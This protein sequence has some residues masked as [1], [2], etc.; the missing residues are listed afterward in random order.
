MER[1]IISGGAPLL[2][3]VRISGAKNAALPI[4]AAAIMTDETLTLQNVPDLSDITQMLLLLEHHGAHI[5]QDKQQK[6]CS[7]QVANIT[8]HVAKY[9]IVRKMRASILVLGPLL[10]R[11][12]EAKVSFPGGCAIGTRPVNV[13]IDGLRMLGAEI[14]V[15]SGYINAVA[16]KNGLKGADIALPIVSVTGTENLLMAATLAEGRT[17]LRNAAK[18][19]EVCDLARCL[20]KMGA[21]IEGIGTDTLVVDGV[22]AL[23]GA[24][25]TII[26]DRIEA[27]TYAAGAVITHG[28]VLLE[29]VVYGDLA[30]FW[31]SLERAGARI[32]VESRIAGGAKEADR[33]PDRLLSNVVESQIAKEADRQPDRLHSSVVEAQIAKE[34]GQQPDRLHS[35]VLVEMTQDIRGVDV[36]TGPYP[37]FPT[38]LQAQFMALMTI[39]SGAAMITETI[40]ENRFMH[41]LELC[42]MGADITVHGGSALV[43]GVKW[44]TGTQVM[45][46][47]IRASV[48]L[49]LAGAATSGTTEIHRIYHIDRGYECIEK[50][51]RGC[52]VNIERAPAE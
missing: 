30:V 33:Q 42:R 35:S 26:P 7:L 45:A 41:V 19:P 27:G 16:S 14:T 38:D 2:G 24:N 37:G 13:H 3:T 4:M 23:H 40:F 43:R 48:S 52:G 8:D 31:E 44:L 11:H 5:T 10:A 34:T 17:I 15:S 18:E 32:S 21:K 9:D 49:V 46:T 51:L 22:S 39:C 25:H 1:I 20:I 28:K 29:N 12:G 36:M 50:K 6:E 47:D